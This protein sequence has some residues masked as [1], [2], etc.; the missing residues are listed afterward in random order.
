MTDL[1]KAL[2]PLLDEVAQLRKEVAR[3]QRGA[4]TTKMQDT[5]LQATALN[6]YDD[7]GN[8]VQVIGIQDD[9]TAGTVTVHGPIPNRPT[10]PT[11]TVAQL[12]LKVAWDG[13]LLD[14]GNEEV[15]VSADFDRVDIHLSTT[16]AFVPSDNSYRK[17]LTTVGETILTPLSTVPYYVALV[18][19]SKAGEESV[20]SAVAGPFTP[21]QV[22]ASDILDG[23]VTSLKLADNAVKAAKIEAGAVTNT[24]IADDSVSTAKLIAGSVSAV[25]LAADSVD[26]SKIVAAS[27]TGDRIAALTITAANIAA[28]TI[29]AGK[30]VAG[31]ITGDRLDINA[32]I[33]KTAQ[34]SNFVN[35]PEQGI[36]GWQFNADGSAYIR[37]ATIGNDLYEI[38]ETGNAKFQGLSVNDLYVDGE[39]FEAV[40]DSLPRGIMNIYPLSGALSYAAVDTDY[41]VTRFVIPAVEARMYRIVLDNFRF[42]RGDAPADGGGT[43]P[44]QMSVDVYSKYGSQASSADSRLHSHLK[45]QGY[46][47]SWSDDIFS[48]EHVFSPPDANLGQDLYIAV[49]TSCN[50]VASHPSLQTDANTRIV[51]EDVGGKV[52]YAPTVSITNYVAPAKTTYVKEFPSTWMASWG[53]GN[54]L[55]TD[56]NAYQG[57]YSSTWAN[58]YTKYGFSSSI[59]TTLSG[60]TVKKVELYLDN[61][62]FYSN[63]G[64][65]AIIGTHANATEPTGSSSTTGTYARQSTAFTKGQAKWVTLA[66]A[67]G[68]D[69]KSGAALGITLGRTSGGSLA[70]YG[71]FASSAKL[72][73]TYEK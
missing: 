58:N 61:N 71:Y 21:S 43:P 63:S 69:L 26:A 62:H 11:V 52:V 46:T 50:G 14:S 60:A 1:V 30:I 48:S 51:V 47:A 15:A 37:S 28:N 9:G 27:I 33:G 40:V 38:N 54:G 34:S 5:S 44:T 70:E 53:S 13:V 36:T 56:S 64:G 16:P 39:D 65:N 19:V 10:T 8:L 66:T 35:D 72:R 67:F 4:A 7:E 6:V 20:A 12:G 49:Y 24:K 2:S 41:L 31:T 55:R 25:K 42:N 45:G 57:N 22:V 23:I 18:A 59:A 32:L 29:T 68:T 73:I 3:L 17:S